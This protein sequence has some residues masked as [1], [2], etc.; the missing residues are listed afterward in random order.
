MFAAL[1]AKALPFAK[2]LGGKALEGITSGITS[3]AEAKTMDLLGQ[4]PG[5]QQKQFMDTAFPGTNPWERLGSSQSQGPVQVARVNNATQRQLKNLEVATTRDVAKIQA[6]ASVI[7]GLGAAAPGEVQKALQALETGTFDPTGKIPGSLETSRMAA[8]AQVRQAEVA[9][10]KLKFEKT[11]KNYELWLS[12]MSEISKRMTARKAGGMPGIMRDLVDLLRGGEKLG[13]KKFMIKPQEAKDIV[14]GIGS[15]PTSEIAN[16]AMILGGFTVGGM[17]IR[18]LKYALTSR[19]FRT[20]VGK[21][22]W[23]KAKQYLLQ[24]QKQGKTPLPK[25]PLQK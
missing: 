12:S 20:T 11:A 25:T 14:T 15:I 7:N 21:V 17:A 23:T 5:A 9:T 19:F 6:R 16:I 22:D 24:Q 4:S 1:A 3:T 13:D 2:K 10:E 8:S 18:A